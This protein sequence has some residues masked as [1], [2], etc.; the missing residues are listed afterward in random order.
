[1]HK[2]SAGRRFLRGYS[3]FVS[4]PCFRRFLL[5]SPPFLLL[6][7][8]VLSFSPPP[9]PPFSPTSRY[10][11]FLPFSF[12]PSICP[13]FLPLLR[14]FLPFSV[15]PSLSPS[16]PFFSSFYL[17]LSD[18]FALYSFF[19][20]PI[21]VSASFCPVFTPLSVLSFHRALSSLY[22]L[23]SLLYFP[24]R[25]STLLFPFVLFCRRPPA[26]PSPLHQPRPGPHNSTVFQLQANY[27]HV[28]HP[29]FY[30][31]GAEHQQQ[32]KTVT[33]SI[34]LMQRLYF[35]SIFLCPTSCV[36][37]FFAAITRRQLRHLFS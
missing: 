17:L 20:F 33:Q 10:L 29:Y 24:C 16:R 4:S 14:L 19:F 23:P 6:P 9:F 5:L 30:K 26:S 21:L 27:V 28:V 13:A 11:L 37:L 12:F 34:A 1:M 31:N 18:L 2:Q 3:L 22:F 35:S 36:M 8:L 7:P 32:H 15:F 25:H